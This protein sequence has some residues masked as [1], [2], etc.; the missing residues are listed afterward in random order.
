M[1][2]GPTD[3]IHRNEAGEVVGWSVVSDE[4]LEDFESLYERDIEDTCEPCRD[5]EHD[6]CDNEACMCIDM[7]HDDD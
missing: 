3:E 6:D 1:F 4:P 5:G 2:P 7:E